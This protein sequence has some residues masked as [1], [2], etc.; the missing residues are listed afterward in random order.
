MYAACTSER[1]LSGVLSPSDLLDLLLLTF[2]DA[3]LKGDPMTSKS[4][5]GWW[6]EQFAPASR[7]SFPLSWGSSRQKS[8][9][10]STAETETVAFAHVA[11]REA[12]PIQMLL[13]EVLPRRLEIA[14]RIDNMQTIQTVT[15]GYSKRL[16]RLPRTQR[17]CVGM[18]H[19]MLND[20]DINMSMEH[21]PTLQMKADIF[22]KALNGPRFKAALE[23]IRMG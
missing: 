7:R 22:T 19:E 23:M 18:L 10:G 9:G 15:K 3:D 20:P 11:R 4:V 14:C 16:R 8:T 12:S 6:I 2:S 13:D 1:V 5:T 21:C 17:V